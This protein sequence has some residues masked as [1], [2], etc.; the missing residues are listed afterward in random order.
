MGFVHNFILASTQTTKY[1][2]DLEFIYILSIIYV[3]L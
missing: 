2:S 1:K 3:F